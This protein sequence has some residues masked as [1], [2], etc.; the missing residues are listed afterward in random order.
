MRKVAFIVSA[1][2]L[3]LIACS[4]GT[5]KTNTGEKPIITVSILPQKF[6]IEQIAGQSVKV[7]VILPPGAS[8]EDFEPSPKQLLDIS[9]SDFFFYVGH[10]GFEKS[11]IKK[12][13]EV[14]HGVRFVSCSNGLDL[15]EESTS[16]PTESSS[17]L[18][19]GTDPH[20]WTSPENVKT[21]SRNICAEMSLV[22]PANKNL[23]EKNL[24]IFI[25]R[26]DSLDNYIR[27]LLNDSI[28]TSFMIFHPALGYFARD[29]HLQ[30]YSIEFDGKTPSTAHMKN[31]IDIARKEKI[32]TVF[33]QAQFETVKAEA[34]AKEIGAKVV[35]I[36]NLGENW[37]SAMYDIAQK[38]KEA[39]T[40]KTNEK[41][42]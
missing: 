24:S 4:A 39:L 37:L 10:L 28:H 30:Q 20:I 11:W 22:Y 2:L 31:M 23:Y 36:D 41:S 38:M 18:N 3:L 42:N 15:L 25:S 5:K 29:Y 1:I 8:P 16:K 19:H 40:I 33:I 12:V 6:F 9:N 14:S 32:K 27:K 34:I 26:I 21:I 7:N 17:H 35:T 13:S